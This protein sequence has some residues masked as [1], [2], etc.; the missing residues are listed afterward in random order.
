VKQSAWFFALISVLAFII[1]WGFWGVLWAIA[2]LVLT[3]IGI[4]MAASGK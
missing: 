3:I 1:G 4:V 2:A